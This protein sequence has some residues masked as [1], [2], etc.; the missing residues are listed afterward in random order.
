VQ[1]TLAAN[2]ARLG[3]ESARAANVRAVMRDHE[4]DPG[5]AAGWDQQAA[6]LNALAQRCGHRPQ[7]NGADPDD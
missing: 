5:R 2:R 7:L 4:P 1:I 6:D 3:R